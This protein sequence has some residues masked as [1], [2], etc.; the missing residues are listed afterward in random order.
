[1]KGIFLIVK[2]ATSISKVLLLIYIQYSM[3]L[4]SVNAVLIASCNISLFVNCYRET[5]QLP[6]FTLIILSIIYIALL[7]L[8]EYEHRKFKAVE[9]NIT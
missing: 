7:I 3:K 4:V 6:P 8:L 9:I 2:K 5:N 1:M